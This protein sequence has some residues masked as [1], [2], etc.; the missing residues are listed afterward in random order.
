MRNSFGNALGGI[1]LAELAVPTATDTGLNTGPVFCILYGS[2][3][4]F[5]ASTLA[6]LYPNHGTYVSQVSR[7][8]ADNLEDGYIV[9]FDAAKTLTGAAHSDI[10]KPQ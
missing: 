5:D 1:Q 10:G 3:V 2:H 7:V 8:T 4:P 6:A 9:P